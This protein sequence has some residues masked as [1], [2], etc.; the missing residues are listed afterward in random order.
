MAPPSADG[1]P[2]RSTDPDHDRRTPLSRLRY[3]D[4]HVRTWQVVLAIGAMVAL[5]AVMGFMLS[6]APHTGTMFVRRS[7]DTHAATVHQPLVVSDRSDTRER[8][9][10]HLINVRREEPAGGYP[11]TIRSTSHSPASAGCERGGYAFSP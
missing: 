7:G 10:G 4:V 11:R 1:G 9:D 5:L 3:G 8:F 2:S 6:R